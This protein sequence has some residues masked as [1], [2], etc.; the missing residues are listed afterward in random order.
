MFIDWRLQ[1]GRFEGP[2]PADAALWLGMVV[3]I[4]G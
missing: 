4:Y 1:S 2:F 3:F